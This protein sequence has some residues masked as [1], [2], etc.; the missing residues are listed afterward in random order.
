MIYRP[1]S[2]VGAAHASPRKNPPKHTLDTPVPIWKRGRMVHKTAGASKLER[3]AGAGNGAISSRQSARCASQ[4][5]LR[6]AGDAR[7]WDTNRYN[8]SDTPCQVVSDLTHSK[9]TKVAH[10]KCHTFRGGIVPGFQD[11]RSARRTV[12]RLRDRANGS[13]FE[14]P[15]MRQEISRSWLTERRHVYRIGVCL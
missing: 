13:N 7:N 14:R 8:Q 9:Q 4:A 6:G 1:P 3:L 12:P 2:T 11:Q 5:S 15:R 10:L